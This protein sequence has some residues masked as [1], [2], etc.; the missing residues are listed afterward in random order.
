MAC[1]LLSN[2][3]CLCESLSADGHLFSPEQQTRKTTIVN[4]KGY[5]I[6]MDGVVYRENQLLPGSREFVEYLIR[7]A[8]PF[9]FLTNNSAPTPEDLVIRMRHLGIAGLSPRHFY[10]S[11]MNTVD[12]LRETH[13]N[14]SAFVIGEAGLTAALAEAKIPNDSIK[15]TYVIIGEGNPSNERLTKAHELIENGARLVVTNPDNWC[16]VKGNQTRPGAGA[17]A[18]YLEAST[19]QRAYFLGKPNPYMFYRARRRLQ[20]GTREIMMIGD[21]METDIRGAI[22][23]GMQA[24]LVLTGSTRLEDIGNYVYQPT[25]VVSGVDELL[26]EI[27]CA[28]EPASSRTVPFPAKELPVRERSKHQTDKAEFFK[29]RP[30]PAMTK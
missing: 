3:Q 6:D 8:T 2:L 1:I 16:P 13:P 25:C 12:F 10:T 15:P 28:S 30:R 22:E 26:S 20:G 11:A 19:G 5:L 14:C 24:C 9:L 7:T 29:P 4:Y 21:T 18:A 23:I 27:Q 17:L